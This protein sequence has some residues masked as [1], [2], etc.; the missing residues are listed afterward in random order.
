LPTDQWIHV[1][2]S[3]DGTTSRVFV[4]GVQVASAVHAATTIGSAGETS[5]ITVGGN[6]NDATGTA[7]ELWKGNIDDV[8]L[9]NRALSQAEIAALV[10]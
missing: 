3:F 9:Y 8:R 7:A 1:A 2:G 5:Q 6:Q 10:Q 4:N